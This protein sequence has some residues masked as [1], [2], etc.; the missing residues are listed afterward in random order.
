[1]A[2][3]EMYDYLAAAVPATTATMNIVPQELLVENGKKNQVAHVFDD[4]SESR[5][6]ISDTSVFYIKLR[7]TSGIPTEDAGTILDFFHNSNLGN[8][9]A[10]SFEWIHPTDGHTYVVRFN[11]TLPREIGIQTIDKHKIQEV[12]LKILGRIND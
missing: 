11:S 3:K 8:G 9:I 12:E 1:M 6:S 2:N 10:R 5:I 4:G 7:W